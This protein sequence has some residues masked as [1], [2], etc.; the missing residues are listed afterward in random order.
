MNCGGTN[1]RVDRRMR[2][3]RVPL[4]PSEI[5]NLPSDEDGHVLDQPT[6]RWMCAGKITARTVQPQRLRRDV[7]V[8]KLGKQCIAGNPTLVDRTPW[9]R[10]SRMT[11]DDAPEDLATVLVH[12]DNGM[13]TSVGRSQLRAASSAFPVVVGP[14]L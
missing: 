4:A 7:G 2:C 13:P 10:P 1:A 6:R 5:D 8:P 14:G 12:A 9:L 11:S 3:V